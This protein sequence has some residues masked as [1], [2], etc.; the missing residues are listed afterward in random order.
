MK[1]WVIIFAFVWPLAAEAD[2]LDNELVSPRFHAD[3][4]GSAYGCG[5]RSEEWAEAAI[6]K[7][8][9]EANAD[10]QAAHLSAGDPRRKNFFVQDIITESYQ[11]GIN[12]SS[13]NCPS[14]LTPSLLHTLDQSIGWTGK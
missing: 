11:Q 2:T 8:W 9:D 6:E 5:A 4:I 12:S 14:W 7:A 3:A 10:V 13:R 1:C